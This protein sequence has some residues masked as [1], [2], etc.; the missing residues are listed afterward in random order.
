MTAMTRARHLFLAILACLSLAWLPGAALAGADAK[1]AEQCFP[2]SN[3]NGFSATDDRTVYLRVGVKDVYRLDLFTDCV[4]L[5]FK[6]SL[7]LETLPASPWICQALDATVISREPGIHQRC[8]VKAIHKLTA[9]EY[10]ALPKRD[11]P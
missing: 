1:S 8:P 7:A 5:T 10:S 3:I 4:D 9:D 11:R 2:V 6:Q